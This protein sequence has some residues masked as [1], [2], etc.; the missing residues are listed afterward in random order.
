MHGC[1]IAA[2]VVIATGNLHF[3]FVWLITLFDSGL[4]IGSSCLTELSIKLRS[5]YS[6]IHGVCSVSYN[7]IS[8]Y[9][10]WVSCVQ[11]KP[12]FVFQRCHQ[13]AEVPSTGSLKIRFV[14]SLPFYCL[15]RSTHPNDK[16]TQFPIFLKLHLPLWIV[17]VLFTQVLRDLS[18]R[19]LPWWC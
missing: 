4:L 5:L 13:M 2:A 1:H 9:R 6:G 17:S 10:K 12:G 8:A 15:M 14:E 16:K 18:L 11:L 7:P 19:F 3:P